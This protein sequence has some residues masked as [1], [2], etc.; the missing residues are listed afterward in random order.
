MILLFR[1]ICAII[2]HKNLRKLD[3]GEKRKPVFPAL[4]SSLEPESQ[5][6]K[7][8]ADTDYDVNIMLLCVR[9]KARPGC[10]PPLTRRQLG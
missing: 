4:P 1:Y 10:T 8:H 3:G 6:Y 5:P 2:K 7:Q 9:L